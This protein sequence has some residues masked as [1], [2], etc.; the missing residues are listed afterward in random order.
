[1]TDTVFFHEDSYCQIEL[2]PKQNY[3]DIGSFPVQEENSFGFEHMLVRD[4]PLFPTVNLGISTQ[5][6]ESLLA[7]NAINYFPVVN[8]GYSTYRVVKEDTVVYGFE[9]LGVFVESKQSIVKNV[10]LGFSSLFTASESCDYLFKVLELIGEKYPLILVDWNG[11]VIVRLQEVDEIQH[12]LESE[13]G[14]KF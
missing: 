5:E 1:M 7:R 4:K 10:W 6:M 11:E 9:R 13:F 3:Q 14:F 8:T 2:L 12:Y